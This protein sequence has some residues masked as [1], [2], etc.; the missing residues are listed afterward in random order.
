MILFSYIKKCGWNFGDLC[1]CA[2]RSSS[3]I[4][5]GGIDCIPAKVI[6]HS[7]FKRTMSSPFKDTDRRSWNSIRVPSALLF[8]KWSL[9]YHNNWRAFKSFVYLLKYSEFFT[10]IFRWKG[11][12]KIFHNASVSLGLKARYFPISLRSS[13]EDASSHSASLRV[14]HSLGHV[15]PWNRI[16]H[17][18]LWPK[19]ICLSTSED[20]R[21]GTD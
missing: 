11:P 12:Q 9:M 10:V 2:R 7:S 20:H 18:F 17:W 16:G 21:C 14:S 6:S 8:V 4:S 15:N 13:G 5:S 1:N 19:C 3:R